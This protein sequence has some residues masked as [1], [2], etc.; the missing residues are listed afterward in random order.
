MKNFST[1]PKLA[2]FLGI[3]F[4]L[5]FFILNALVAINAP[6]VLKLLRPDAHTTGSEQ[7]LIFGLISLVCIGGLISLYPA[8][9]TRRLVILNIVVGVLLIGFSVMAGY[10]LG[11]DVYHCNIL[12]IPNCD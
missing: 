8:I 1:E 11:I 12:K 2:L 4:A 9:K 6:A 5:P 7:I 3:F 10:G